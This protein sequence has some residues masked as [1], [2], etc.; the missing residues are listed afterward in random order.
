MFSLA[1]IDFDLYEPCKVALEYV[2]KRLAPGG[3]IVFDEALTNFWP[4]EGIAL[5]EYLA[6]KGAGEYTMQS[7]TFARQPTVYLIKK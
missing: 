1:Y 7:I 4:G 3:I 2:G 6:Q 5:I